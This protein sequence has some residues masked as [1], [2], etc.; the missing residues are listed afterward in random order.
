MARIRRLH[1]VDD[2]LD[3]L[4]GNEKVAKLTGHKA[5]AVSAWR[6]VLEGLPSKTYVVL[7]HA[8][9]EKGCEAPDE[10]WGMLPT[11]EDA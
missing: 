7:K 6:H 8:L 4:G 1:T 10:L 11:K 3:V 5:K 2:I 9:R